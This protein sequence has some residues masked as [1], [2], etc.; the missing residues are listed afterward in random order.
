VAEYAEN[1]VNQPGVT[2]MPRSRSTRLPHAG[3]DAKRS[4]P[5]DVFKH[6]AKSQHSVSATASASAQG[7]Q[8]RSAP[9]FPPAHCPPPPGAKRTHDGNVDELESDL[10]PPVR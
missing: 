2:V 6:P 9:F 10:Q 1:P 3:T 5:D 4:R 7:L 8:A